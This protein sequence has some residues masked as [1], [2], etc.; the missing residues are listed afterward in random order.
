MPKIPAWLKTPISARGVG[1]VA[2]RLAFNPYTAAVAGGIGLGNIPAVKSATRRLWGISDIET[3]YRDYQEGGGA[4][5]YNAWAR[6]GKPK[7]AGLTEYAR[8]AEARAATSARTKEQ[9]EQERVEEEFRTFQEEQAALEEQD[10]QEQI[11][12]FEVSEGRLRGEGLTPRA[13]YR[14][15]E[16][17]G[18]RN[19]YDDPATE[20]V[21]GYFNP[22]TGKWEPPLGW[23][24]STATRHRLERETIR[25]KSKSVPT[26]TATATTDATATNC[27]GARAT[28]SSIRST[29]TATSC[30]T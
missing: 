13:P 22:E 12:Q 20:E 19:R 26:A 24:S 1:G 6:A 10:R 9:K 21:E 7:S 27:L 25:A 3:A 17:E 29:K 2:G 16:E 8:G 14:F 28:A 15:T 4:L 18:G 30:P 23:V 11:R 5:S